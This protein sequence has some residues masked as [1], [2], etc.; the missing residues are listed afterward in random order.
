[1]YSNKYLDGND[2]ITALGENYISK[3]KEKMEHHISQDFL[4][5]GISLKPL[6]KELYGFKYKEE[7][8]FESD[9]NHFTNKNGDTISSRPFSPDLTHQPIQK[10][11]V[12]NN[13]MK[14]EVNERVDYNIPLGLKSLS[15]FTY[16][17]CTIPVFIGL[18]ENNGK[19]KRKL[20]NGFDSLGKDDH[21]KVF[22]PNLEKRIK[23]LELRLDERKSRDGSVKFNFDSNWREI[24]LK[25]EEDR[26][27]LF[28][29]E[30]LKGFFCSRYQIKDLE[31]ADVYSEPN[32]MGLK[33]TK[34]IF[35]K[36]KSNRKLLENVK[37]G[38]D[39]FIKRNFTS[40]VWIVFF[41][42]I[43]GDDFIKDAVELS[44][45]VDDLAKNRLPEDKI[46]DKIVT[47]KN[48]RQILV[49]IEE[50]RLLEEIDIMNHMLNLSND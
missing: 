19:L 34:E 43:P 46:L 18:F 5:D 14:V 12:E 21:L 22:L 28:S 29:K 36:S 13:L 10:D 37:R 35:L 8:I 2:S 27:F 11:I 4:V 1:M 49:A 20:I 45:L 30:D 24:D 41:D 33:V 16:S 6:P 42:F 26:L 47:Y 39:Y 50:Y 17:V 7:Y 23:N 25:R 15:S 31:L 48:Y 38:T 40:G 44:S 9:Y 3:E 32:S